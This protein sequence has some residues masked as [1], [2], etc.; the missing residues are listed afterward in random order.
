MSPED[1]RRFLIELLQ[2][3]ERIGEDLALKS[4]WVRGLPDTVL[5]PRRDAL[6]RLLLNSEESEVDRGTRLAE[7]ARRAR[8]EG[9]FRERTSGYEHECWLD[10]G[11][12]IATLRVA[13]PLHQWLQVVVNPP[14]RSA[15]C[16]VCPPIFWVSTDLNPAV[17]TAEAGRVAPWVASQ[18]LAVEED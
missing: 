17:I 18:I 14:Q 13:H 12:V 2:H 1:H 4:Q 10:D 9:H 15:D 8:T 11:T 3:L 16:R 6:R 7:S 5:Q